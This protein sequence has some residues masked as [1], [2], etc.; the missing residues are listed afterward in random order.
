MINTKPRQTPLPNPFRRGYPP[1]I[2]RIHR[3][4]TVGG[5]NGTT[6]VV[7]FVDC[8]VCGLWY[9][10]YYSYCRILQGGRFL[11]PPEPLSVKL[12]I[13]TNYVSLFSSHLLLHLILMTSACNLRYFLQWVPAFSWGEKSH[14]QACRCGSRSFNSEESSCLGKYEISSC[15]QLNH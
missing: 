10:S 13:K 9:F 15:S 3:S 12:L 11:F 8:C 7:M 14:W 6:M 4:H 5:A 2:G 1:Q